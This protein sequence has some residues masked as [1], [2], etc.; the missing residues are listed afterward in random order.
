MF[1]FLSIT[2]LAQTT[3]HCG[4][5]LSTCGGSWWSIANWFV[6]W[7]QNLALTAKLRGINQ[8]DTEDPP[9]IYFGR[10][11]YIAL[12]YKN[13]TKSHLAIYQLSLCFQR[14]WFAT[15]SLTNRGQTN[16][17]LVRPLFGQDGC[18]KKCCES[19]SWLILTLILVFIILIIV[20]LLD[21]EGWIVAHFYADSRWAWYD[22][23]RRPSVPWSPKALWQ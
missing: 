5:D 7:G 22:E 23:F 18:S 9:K 6:C 14:I 11:S 13:W 19:A 21:C 15:H 2:H 1:N 16:R 3:F 20:T 17:W 4:I 8:L 12:D 10:K